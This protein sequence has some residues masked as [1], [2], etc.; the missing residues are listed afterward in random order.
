MNTPL[1]HS[2]LESRRTGRLVSCNAM[3]VED[4]FLHVD[5][6]P[7]TG[8]ANFEHCMRGDMLMYVE[9]ANS[10]PYDGFKVPKEC[11]PLV[12]KSI[13][14]TCVFGDSDI[15]RM[16]KFVVGVNVEEGICS[17][18]LTSKIGK[19]VDASILKCEWNGIGYSILCILCWIESPM[20]IGDNTIMASMS[21]SFNIASET[22]CQCGK[23][24][25]N[26]RNVCNHIKS[27]IS[28]PGYHADSAMSICEFDSFNKV[29]L[30]GAQIP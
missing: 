28:A 22:C 25:F 9:L 17:C 10:T 15:R 2:E 21:F 6:T 12:R 20:I 4:P 1:L 16:K 8:F 24:S 3:A 18:N 5:C 11:K 27:S 26:G 7:D 29:L 23:I 14:T 30:L 13:D 19:V